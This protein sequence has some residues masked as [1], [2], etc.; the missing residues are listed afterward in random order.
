[1]KAACAALGIPRSTVYRHRRPRPAKTARIVKPPRQALTEAEE[2]EILAVLHSERFVDRS[3]AEVYATLLDEGTYLCSIRTMYRLLKRRGEVRERRNVLSHPPYQK[4]ELLATKPDEVWSWDITKLRG[5]EKWVYYCLYVVLDIFSRYVVGWM[6]AATENADLATHLIAETC[7][8]EGIREDQL[9]IHADRGSPMVSKPLGLLLTDLGVTKSHSR[10][11][12]SNDNPFSEA[13][14]KTLKYCPEFPDR[15]GS[16][17]DARS[18]CR[19]F[20]AWYNHEHHHSGLAMLTP[21]QVHHGQTK[22]VVAFRQAVL[23]GA[24]RAH[25]ERF[26][27]PPSPMPPPTAAWIN[28]PSDT[29][30]PRH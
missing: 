10:P 26:A 1:M 23:Q 4:P 22:E 19:R 14:F 8:K 25:P 15:F 27:R 11:H 28:P 13:Q 9:T 5:P 29:L 20:F 21:S 18:F 17:E 30:H 16:I 7:R 3:P 6:V 2:A 24:Y 12:V